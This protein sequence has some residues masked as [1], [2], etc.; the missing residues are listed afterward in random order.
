L[1]ID[2]TNKIVNANYIITNFI[3]GDLLSNIIDRFSKKKRKRLSFQLGEQLGK[4]N[5]IEIKTIGYIFAKRY[6][7]WKSWF[8]EYFKDE[9]IKNFEKGLINKRLY[10]L[11]MCFIKKNIDF[12]DYTCPINLFIEIII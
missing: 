10:A 1:V 4:I 11:L 2:D 12:I 7:C 6:S 9:T 8:Y 3:E 5:Q